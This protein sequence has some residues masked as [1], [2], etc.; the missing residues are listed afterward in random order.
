MLVSPDFVDEARDSLALTTFF[1]SSL[2][3][4][5]GVVL[6]VFLGESSSVLSLVREGDEEGDGAVKED[7]IIDCRDS[8]PLTLNV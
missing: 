7:L 5:T 3:F 1:V 6:T 4:L 2:I 8:L